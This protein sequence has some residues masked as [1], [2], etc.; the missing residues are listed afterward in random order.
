[1]LFFF[2]EN[3]THFNLEIFIPFPLPPLFLSFPSYTNPP[4]ICYLALYPFLSLFLFLHLFLFIMAKNGHIFN[5]RK[6]LHF[7][8]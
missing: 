7:I 3:F 6:L 8:L 1:M 4:P 2:R 5:N